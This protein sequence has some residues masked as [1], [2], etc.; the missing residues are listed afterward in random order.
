MGRNR[1]DRCTRRR[2]EDVSRQND[3]LMAVSISPIEKGQGI[4]G[5]QLLLWGRIVRM[6][7]PRASRALCG[8]AAV[9]FAY[10]HD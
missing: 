3:A 2:F 8:G 10:L 6:V 9:F 1:T 7:F 5:I 4:P